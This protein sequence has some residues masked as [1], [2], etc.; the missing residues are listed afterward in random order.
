MLWTELL[1]PQI[2][3]HKWSQLIKLNKNKVDWDYYKFMLAGSATFLFLLNLWLSKFIQL[4]TM[5]EMMVAANS[6][7]EL[8]HKTWFYWIMFTYTREYHLMHE[9]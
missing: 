4:Q 7:E 8:V 2:K 5:E 6:R 9:I 1:P 3:L